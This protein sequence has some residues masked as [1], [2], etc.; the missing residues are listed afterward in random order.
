VPANDPNVG[1]LVGWRAVT[2]GSSGRLH[3]IGSFVRKVYHGRE[4][5]TIRN[6]TGP[7]IVF[8]STGRDGCRGTG[9][10]HH[11]RATATVHVVDGDRPRRPD[12]NSLD[13]AAP[14]ALERYLA[15]VAADVG[16][17][18]RRKFVGADLFGG[19]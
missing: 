2:T 18:D 19:F 8:H 4:C 11:H 14:R 17:A 7:S 1:F 15:A 9:P 10:C 16:W 6:A 12:L 3:R 13:V 5:Q